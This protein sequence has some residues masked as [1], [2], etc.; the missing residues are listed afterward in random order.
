MKSKKS[1]DL[2][3]KY[4]K[5]FFGLGIFFF[6]VGLFLTLEVLNTKNIISAYLKIFTQTNFVFLSCLAI[7]LLWAIFFSLSNNLFLSSFI[8][9]LVLYFFYLINFYRREITGWVFVPSDLNFFKSFQSINSFAMLKFHSRIIVVPMIIFFLMCALSFY[10]KKIKIKFKIRSCVKI[11]L[12]SIIIFL[13]MFCSSFSR[14]N[15]MPLFGLDTRIKFTSNQ[16]YDKYGVIM[17]FYTMSA[18]KNNLEPENYNRDTIK[19]IAD[20][21]DQEYPQDIFV[22]TKIKKNIKPNVIIIMSEAFADPTRWSNINFSE[23]PIPN[24]KNLSRE[25]IFG[26]LITPSFGGS[27]CNV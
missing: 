4:K 22:K 19:K 11:F 27:T 17:G 8:L 15:I 3:Q 21:I 1:F 25:S 23:E 7:F 16:I 6:V 18:Q 14:I 20:K 2:T 5:I 9:S 12:S 10:C 26:N 13:F 24:L